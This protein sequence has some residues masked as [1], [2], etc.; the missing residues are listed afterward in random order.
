MAKEN[1][2]EANDSSET[3]RCPLCFKETLV[4]NSI[5]L[6]AEGTCSNCDD[7]LTIIKLKPLTVEHWQEPLYRNVLDM[8][9]PHNLRDGGLNFYL[10]G[11]DDDEL[12]QSLT[13]AIVAAKE[14]L[15]DAYDKAL[16]EWSIEWNV[17]EMDDGKSE[18][19][20]K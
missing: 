8:E 7:W 15:D 16:K 13:E 17:E 4:F 11:D 3:V 10:R 5:E 19:E 9:M 14:M 6:E 2:K 12:V 1:H 20:I 18:Y